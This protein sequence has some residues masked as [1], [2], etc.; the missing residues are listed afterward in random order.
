MPHVGVMWTSIMACSSGLGRPLDVRPRSL[1]CTVSSATLPAS[2][3][4]PGPPS[5][6]GPWRTPAQLMTG[7]ADRWPSADSAGLLL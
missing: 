4:E 1:L 2:C 7:V 3:V 5:F 6:V